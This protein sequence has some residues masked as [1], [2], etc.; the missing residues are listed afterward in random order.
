MQSYGHIQL[1]QVHIHLLM[2]PEDVHGQH[3]LINDFINNV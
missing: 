1:K 3:Y 2:K